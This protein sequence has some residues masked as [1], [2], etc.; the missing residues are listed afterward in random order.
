M[1][2][3]V[4]ALL[5]SVVVG[6]V[7]LSASAVTLVK[8]GKPVATIVIAKA[9]FDA[10]P[11]V[12]AVGVAG[13][14]NS[15][16]RLAADD[17]Q[18]YIEKITGA[19]L[20]IVADDQPVKGALVLV[21]ASKKTE[22]LNLKI[23]AG[24]TPDRKEE[25]YLI[26]ANGDTLVLA[27]NND[28]PYLGTY[29]AVAEFLNRQG[30][31]W[32]MPSEFGEVLPKKTANLEV[33]DMEF[34]DKPD[35]LVRCWNGNL[36]PELHLDD[37]F[38]RIR[39]KLCLSHNDFI[40]IPG[41][42]YLRKY[43]PAKELMATHP[44]YWAKNLD[45]SINPTMVSLSNPDVPKLVAEKVIAEI[46]KTRETNPTFNSLGFA[47]DDGIP[48]DLAPE[49]MKHS[50]GFTDLVGREGVVTELSVSEEWFAFMNKVT[51]E[52]NKVYPE[53][54]ITTNGYTN[55]TTPPEGVKINPQMGV[56]F[57]AIWSD[58]LHSFD[59]PKSWQQ[60]VQ[61][62]MLQRWGQICSRVFVYNYNFPML[63]TGLTPMPLTRKIARNTPL[64]KKWGI[65]GFEDEQTFPW[66]AHG[67]TSFYLRARMYW[68]ADTDAK[69]YLDDYF[70]KWYGPAAKSSA[71][72]WDAI[73]E[74]LE[75]TPLLGHEDRVLPYVYTDKCLDEMEKQQKK[76]EAAAT[77]EPY[78]TRV[79]VDRLI[80]DHLKGYVA[81]NR[82]EFTGNY[83]EAIKQA[84]IMFAQRAALH[85]ISGFFNQPETTD[86]HRKYFSGSYYWNLTQRKA[87]YQK[88]LDMTTGKTGDLAVKAPRKTRFAIDD[89]DIG[90]YA[91]WEDPSFD[92]SKWK[93]IDT[94]TPFYLQD[95]AWLD[96]RGAP[97]VGYIWYVFDLDVPKEKIG[98]PIHVYAPIVAAEA[99]VW[100]NGEFSGH[101][102][103]AEAYIRPAP[104]EFDVTKQVKAGKNVVAVRVSTT[105]SRIQV[106][107]GFQGP[108][109]LYSPK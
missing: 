41:D 49:T 6:L 48:M 28:G 78:K 20:P 27:G 102:P 105:L 75:S 50:L 66:M 64:M 22:P 35:F 47:P 34:R 31:R 89:L 12:P 55:R 69:A 93:M 104:V 18:R 32:F 92:R 96:K 38:F 9:A 106:S 29:Y 30:V 65:I 3:T 10:K 82:A 21:G 77:E 85:D 33:K 52:V 11:F 42:S 73:E 40:A 79:R 87:M 95:P 36:A 67:I 1:R 62:E 45:G 84:D 54:V 103:Y 109:F 37:A 23:P 7:S 44:E 88:L 91:R 97:Y 59:D 51:E 72:Y 8:D 43:L 101:R 61:G 90:R 58:L 14:P 94:A 99:W 63:V 2:R 70:E 5:K 100:T 24:M 25:G 4:L 68:D 13:E 98:K 74:A 39:N 26:Y 16:I 19:K 53:F 17:L 15:K 60:Q 57:A 46:K 76:S 107:E 80:L 86:P 81:M 56:M 71:A 83:P 108:L